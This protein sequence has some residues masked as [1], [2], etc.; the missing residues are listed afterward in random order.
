MELLELYKEEN[1]DILYSMSWLN[2][3]SIFDKSIGSFQDIDL[4]TFLENINQFDYKKDIFYDDVYYILE[5]TQDT[6]LYLIKNINKE[7]K[8]EHRVMPISQAKEF[9]RVSILWL[10]R[11]NG[12][13][14]KE[15]LS[16]GKI[17]AVQRYSN[18]DTYEN[19]IFKILLKKLVLV[20]EERDDLEEFKHLF[21]KIRKWLK[22]DEAKSIDEYK[23]IVYNNIL[24]HHKHYSKIFKSYKWFNSLNEKVEK[25]KDIYP[26]QIRSILKFEIL[27][28]L[29]FKSNEYILPRTLQIDYKDN[30]FELKVKDYILDLKLDE[31]VSRITTNVLEKKLPLQLINKFSEQIIKKQLKIKLDQYRVFYVEN[32]TDEVFI[33]FFRLFPIV[34]VEEKIIEFPVTIKQKIDNSIVNANNTKI[35]DLNH[36]IYTLPEVLKTFDTSILKYFLDDFIHHFKDTQLNYIVPDYVNVFEFA[37]VKKTIS[38]Y[39]KNNKPIPKSILASLKYL[40]KS[41]VKR[42]DT[43]IYIQ[44]NHDNTLFVTPLLIRYDKKLELITNGLYIEKHPTKKFK[45]SDDILK[46]LNKVFSNDIVSKKMLNSFLQ[47]GLKSIKKEKIVFYKNKKIISLNQFEI[48]KSRHTNSSLDEIKKLYKTNKLFNKKSIMISDDKI[49]NL[50]NFEKLLQNE[51]NGHILWREHLPSLSMEIIRDGYFDEFVL[52][53]DNTEIVDKKI[54]IQEQF[55]IP[56]NTSEL[57]FPLVF[58]NQKIGYIADLKSKEFPFKENIEC[59]LELIYDY[60]S[61]DIYQL[62]FIPLD[63]TFPPIRVEWQKEKEKVFEKLIYPQYPKTSVLEENIEDEL[64]KEFKDL[65]KNVKAVKGNRFYEKDYYFLK[66]PYSKA[67]F[68]QYWQHGN[69]ILNSQND[70]LKQLIFSSIKEFIEL[71]DNL[72]YELKNNIFLFLSYLHKDLIMKEKTDIFIVQEFTKKVHLY[73]LSLGC[74]EMNWQKTLF[75]NIFKEAELKQIKILNIAMWRCEIVVE[76][77]DTRDLDKLLKFIK[78]ELKFSKNEKN[79]INYLEFLLASLRTKS[80][81]EVLHLNKLITKDILNTLKSR[82]KYFVENYKLKSKINFG[83]IDKPDNL[84]KMPDILYAV[85]YYLSNEDIEN[86]IIINEVSA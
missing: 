7:I 85:I 26:E 73:G 35:I 61:E 31:T 68:S 24:L 29:Q 79:I 36:E 60:E 54:D 65:E 83:K 44:K 41:E 15:K 66:K 53:D 48:V 45:E 52:V 33:D 37:Q 55:T 63:E 10:S 6:I 69:S 9:D 16:G 77:I 80:S 1:R 64:L 23:K 57:S 22:N 74:V 5:Y 40:F 51:K 39:F 86:K 46:S 25:Y 56:K 27:S 75:K 71:K 84:S 14:L 21:I 58:D 19:R 47:N 12:R 76:R 30:N 17:K 3:N 13:T 43:L 32:K 78:K 42:D 34:K 72:P 59:K 4:F 50:K 18:L 8:R 70:E 82:S 81:S 62:S 20:Y 49:E 67:M 11:K 38:S 2:K 28:Q